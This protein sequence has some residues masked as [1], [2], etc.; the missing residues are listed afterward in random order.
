MRY[1]Y[2]TFSG[3]SVYMLIRTLFLASSDTPELMPMGDEPLLWV[4]KSIQS[5]ACL[6]GHGRCI[7]AS[8]IYVGRIVSKGSPAHFYCFLGERCRALP[9]E[10]L[11]LMSVPITLVVR[12]SIS[13]L[14]RRS[15]P[16]KH[17]SGFLVGDA[18]RAGSLQRPLF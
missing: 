2:P 8:G 1:S 14:N 3:K 6:T 18:S 4:G 15:P 17:A 11:V 12:Y 10:L 13:P 7:M 5:D 9:Y 16:K